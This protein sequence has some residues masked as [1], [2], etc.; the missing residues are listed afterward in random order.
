MNIKLTLLFALIPL[1]I[2]NAHAME[3]APHND[4]YTLHYTISVPTH[5]ATLAGRPSPYT[6]RDT[7]L[8]DDSNE[9][10]VPFVLLDTA[11]SLLLAKA[12][13][14][15]VAIDNS[16]YYDFTLIVTDNKNNMLYKEKGSRVGYGGVDRNVGIM[17]QSALEWIKKLI[18][19]DMREIVV[20]TDT[21]EETFTFSKIQ[22]F[23]Y[24]YVS[25]FM[26][27]PDVHKSLAFPDRAVH[28]QVTVDCKGKPLD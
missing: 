4:D 26:G 5:E 12:P 16:S 24:R 3:L 6:V 2:N 18:K 1:C 7:L 23:L 9:H 20:C 25:S 10:V 13:E 21:E 14:D 27:Y 17:L 11:R 15:R 22:R 19:K 8:I 28:L